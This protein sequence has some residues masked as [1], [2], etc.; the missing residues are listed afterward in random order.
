MAVLYR[1]EDEK[2]GETRDEF[3]EAGMQPDTLDVD[4]RRWVRMFGNRQRSGDRGSYSAAMGVHP[5]Q[6]KEATR[7]SVEH[8]YD[9]HFR[10]D[11]DMWVHGNAHR[12]KAM[13]ENG[14]RD[15]DACYRQHAGG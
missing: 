4:G 13:I 1:Y 10:P 15:K 8:G 12:N 9:T 5:S 3:F 6:I 7:H 14:L 2:T 11:G